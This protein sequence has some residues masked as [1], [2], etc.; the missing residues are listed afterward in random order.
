[1]RRAAFV[2]A[3]TLAGLAGVAGI[4]GL[5][6]IAGS[7]S[8]ASAAPLAA[9]SLEARVRAFLRTG[10]YERALHLV[11]AE[12]KRS[13]SRDRPAP[14]AR[15]AILGARAEQALGRLRDARARLEEASILAPDDLPLRAA[16]IDAADAVG[17]RLAVRG[18]VDRTYR[19]WRTSRVNRQSAPDLVAVAVAA[20]QENDWEGAN[21][22][23]REAVQAD[24]AGVEANLLWG[25]VF[26]EK[27]NAANAAA[28][29][30]D[31]CR[32]DPGNPDGHA[33]LAAALLE[34][35]FD[36]VGAEREIAAALAVNPRHSRALALRAE[37]ALDAEELD[38]VATIVAAM[39]KTNPRDA[40][41]DALA[42]A[43]ALLQEDRP[44]YEAARDARLAVRPRDTEL[45][46]FVAEALVRQRRYEDARD[47]AAEGVQAGAEHA[48]LLATLGNTLLR[49]G[50]ER[51]GL[52]ILR[53]A[54]E[55]DPYNTRVYNLL[56]LFEKVIPSRYVTL[57]T[58]HLSFRV[59]RGTEAGITE[60]VAPFLEATYSDYVARYG[61]R[62]HGPI[63][64]ELYG[65]PE[66]FAV[67]AVGLPQLG[68]SGVC[69]GRVITSHAP[70]R[71]V[72]NWALV[73]AHELAHV[74]AL[75]LSRGRVP[76]WF[77]EGLAEAE[78]ARLR[79]EWQRHDDLMLWGALVTDALPSIADLSQAFVRARHAEAASLAY[80]A[81]AQAVA[82]L[83]RRFGFPKLR[84]A[85]EAWGRGARGPAVL[86]EA[87]GVPAANLDRAFK[88][89]LRARF[90]GLRSQ[91][92]PATVA[93]GR[94]LGPRP[95]PM[96]AHGATPAALAEH[97]L[98]CLDAHDIP[99][100]ERAFAR[101][102]AAAPADSTTVFLGADLALHAGRA[103]EA[104]ALFTQLLERGR[105]G[106]DVR[107]RLALASL[108]LGDRGS[109]T[110]HLHR[111]VDLVPSSVEALGLLAEHL[112]ALGE[113]GEQLAAKA[114]ALRLEPQG[115]A[116]AKEVVLGE[117]R[118]GH[119]TEVIASARIAL[120]I[121]PADPDMHAALG[122][123]LEATG[124]RRDAIAALER[125]L[126]FG[127]HDPAALH[128]R[129]ADLYR[130]TGDHTRAAL[131]RAALRPDA[132][133]A[134]RP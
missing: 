10:A 122:R 22:R 28:S 38:T 109:A 100:A 84:A 117:A 11:D 25:D 55:I 87:F 121:A 71:G 69:F 39:R 33:G 56:N 105:E 1:M 68:V 113:L 129:L 45:F 90:A 50:D 31:V 3:L 66:E 21:D 89:D 9:S 133:T 104:R 57:H 102:H 46:F 58:P 65:K 112:G 94:E 4:D 7:R 15:L 73:L 5:A 60:V 124:A 96:P 16:L 126:R 75:E 48:R 107:L 127:P 35:T 27:H 52:G 82:Y 125:A 19:D 70:H 91:F 81:S 116:L 20:R 30:R 118:A 80:L 36:T 99:S 32:V 128:R 53:R 77:T 120:D 8:G 131:H 13:G 47:V 119:P 93:R 108:S 6:G 34:S 106:Y 98:R 92:L 41:A 62:P 37:L 63:V 40:R 134:P 51:A 79:P 67:R 76:R 64:F 88:D 23:L 2:L 130:T 86:A 110:T 42:A 61:F 97:G 114:R 49:L 18:F 85:L 29:F 103:E 95:V 111:A 24:P 72:H 74:F 83:E 12:R 59:E 17:D 101:A 115:L 43:T 123:A 78:T 14:M 26:L 54:W 44:A 132:G